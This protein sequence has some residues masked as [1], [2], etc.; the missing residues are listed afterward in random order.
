M[1][2]YQKG[3]CDRRAGLFFEDNPYEQDSHEYDQW[4]EG[5]EDEE[6]EEILNDDY[7]QRV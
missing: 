5:Y 1:T 4:R 2:E 7:F 6:V 3:R